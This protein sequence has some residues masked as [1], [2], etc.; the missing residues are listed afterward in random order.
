MSRTRCLDFRKKKAR[1]T[2]TASSQHHP[3]RM[4]TEEHI[5]TVQVQM[6]VG[7]AQN[8]AIAKCNRTEEGSLRIGRYRFY[9][10]TDQ[11]YNTTALAT[12]KNVY[13]KRYPGVANE[14]MLES[15]LPILRQPGVSSTLCQVSALTFD[16]RHLVTKHYCNRRG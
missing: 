16:C 5:N 2:T 3:L 15:Q 13:D 12:T 11:V 7:G 10:N 9:T 6:A 14:A 8:I 4:L 1:A